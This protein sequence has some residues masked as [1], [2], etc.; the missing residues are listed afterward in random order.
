MVASGTVPL[1]RYPL[2]G[3]PRS[4]SAPALRAAWLP[5]LRELVRPIYLTRSILAAPPEGA[6]AE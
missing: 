5:R 1:R 2:N 6:A 3:R 4:D